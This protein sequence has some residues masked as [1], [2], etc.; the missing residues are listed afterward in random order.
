MTLI[1]FENQKLDPIGEKSLKV[2]KL[3]EYIAMVSEIIGQG[4]STSFLILSNS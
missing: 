4:H 3:F 1:F 2:T